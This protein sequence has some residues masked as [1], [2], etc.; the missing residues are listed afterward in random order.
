MTAILIVCTLIPAAVLA[1]FGAAICL[2]RGQQRIAEI[3]DE[4]DA[5]RS[6]TESETDRG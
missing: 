4:F 3:L 5:A 2:D 6:N 1:L